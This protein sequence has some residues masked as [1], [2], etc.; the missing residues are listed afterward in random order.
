MFLIKKRRTLFSFRIGVRL[1]QLFCLLNYFLK[2]FLD[3]T[4]STF[5]ASNK[6]MPMPIV[7]T[8]LHT[9][10]PKVSSEPE[11][12]KILVKSLIRVVSNMF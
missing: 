8:L 9:I 1:F 11:A 5:V 12:K 6:A 10:F 3:A 2:D 4:I 7:P